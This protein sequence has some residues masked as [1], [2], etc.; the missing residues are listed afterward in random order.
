MSVTLPIDEQLSRAGQLVVRARIFLDVWWA[1][2]ASDS[3]PILLPPMQHYPEF[4]RFDEHAHLVSFIVHIAA[5]FENDR[6]TVNFQR[7]LKDL[8]ALSPGSCPFLAEAA[9]RLS[10]IDPLTKKISILRNNLFAHRSASLS[11]ADA[12][13][14][15]AI[16]ANDFHHVTA[17]ALA[18]ANSLLKARG[19]QP[20]FFNEM[21]A[22]HFKEAVQD[23]FGG[24]CRE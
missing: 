3:R 16:T 14:K 2:N 12:F 9:L 21:P 4:F 7:L 10:Q 23:L 11:Y 13:Q 19:L 1:Y 15:A 20:Q 24:A 5:L 18:I 17:E 22:Q 6:R 8:R